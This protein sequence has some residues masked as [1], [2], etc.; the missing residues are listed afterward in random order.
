MYYLI[1]RSE[2]NNRSL[3]LPV[4][5]RK[6]LVSLKESILNDWPE[7]NI[8]LFT[9]SRPSAYSEYEPFQFVESPEEFIHEISNLFHLHSQ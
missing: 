4:T 7:T 2:N 6:E 5:Q 9:V 8:Q 1:A 3:V